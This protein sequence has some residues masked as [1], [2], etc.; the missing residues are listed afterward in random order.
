MPVKFIDSV[1]SDFLPPKEIIR[2]HFCPN[3]TI[4]EID[5][6]LLRV[7]AQ[8]VPKPLPVLNLETF[9]CKRCGHNQ[10]HV[11]PTEYPTHKS[12]MSCGLVYPV[13]YKGKAYRDIKD[14]ADRNTCGYTDD[15]MSEEF[16][17]SGDYNSRDRHIMKAR[18][19]FD[20]ISAKLHFNTTPKKA[21]ELYGCFLDGI[22]KERNGKVVYT[23]KNADMIYAACMFDCLLPPRKQALRKKAPRYTAPRKKRRPIQKRRLRVNM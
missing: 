11:P 14:R 5:R 22:A 6:A 4:A 2:R 9:E 10:L 7:K 17:S 16:N 19:E 3:K 1:K 15:L 21:I 13:I 23:V 18:G 20:D 12:C 8:A